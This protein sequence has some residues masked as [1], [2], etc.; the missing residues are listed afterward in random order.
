MTITANN[1]NGTRQAQLRNGSGRA[2]QI[3]FVKGGEVKGSA[4]E[5]AQYDAE[6]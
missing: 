5:L 6:V 2:G 4:P 3:A 1:S